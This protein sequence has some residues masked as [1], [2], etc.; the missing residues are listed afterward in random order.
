MDIRFYKDRVILEADDN[1][2]DY[3]DI[4]NKL[5]DKAKEKNVEDPFDMINQNDDKKTSKKDTTVS[6]VIDSSTS[7]KNNSQKNEINTLKNDS[8]V[9]I[10]NTK[11]EADIISQF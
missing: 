3:A 2:I 8:E 7:E 5:S 6:D 4:L 1:K 11:K 10:F 9:I